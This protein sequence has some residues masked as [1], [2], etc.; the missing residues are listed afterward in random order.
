MIAVISL[1]KKARDGE[2]FQGYFWH[3]FPAH[4]VEYAEVFEV[5]A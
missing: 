2:N 3:A 4:A 1:T 5:Q